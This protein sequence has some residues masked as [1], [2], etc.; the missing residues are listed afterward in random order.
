MLTVDFEILKLKNGMRLLDA[1][2]GSGRHICHAYNNYAVDVVGVDKNENDLAKTRS[3][4]QAISST[5]YHEN[6]WSLICTDI[7]NL[8][9]PDESFDVIICSEVLEHVVMADLALNELT[10]LLKR[11]GIMAISI[12][13]FFPERICWALSDDYHNEAGG[14]IRIYKKKELLRMLSSVGLKYKQTCYKHGLHSPYWWLKCL[15]GHKKEDVKIVN[16]YKKILEWD[17]I[18]KPF[19]TRALDKFL[20]LFIAKS[21]VVY[22]QKTEG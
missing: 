19:I 4:L 13:Q 14:H 21:I 3:L 10:R 15:V 11:G 12:P 16:L 9:F 5:K 7:T 22:V 1:G 17:I 6:N 8:S 2:C 18:K 20:N